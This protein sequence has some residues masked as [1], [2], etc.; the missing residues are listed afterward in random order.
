MDRYINDY[1]FGERISGISQFYFQHKELIIISKGS[2]HNHQ[3]YA[4]GYIE[5]MT[6]CLIIADK[7]YTQL[8]S[9]GKLNFS[10]QSACIVLFFHDIEKIWKY[11]TGLSETF[12]KTKWY[13]DIL[14]DDYE[15]CFSSD[16]MNALKYIHG[17]GQDYKS[18]AR[19]MNPLAA[20]CHMVDVT[21]ARIFFDQKL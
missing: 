9:L 12:D 1:Y 21:S 4:G 8:S 19:V 6:Q 13:T 5:H 16:E 3:A 20:F 10:L 14:C 15:I 17:E 2:G 18:N 7:L 11:T